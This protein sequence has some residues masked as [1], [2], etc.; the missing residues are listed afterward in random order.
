M[1]ISSY[2]EATVLLK[3]IDAVKKELE[4][5]NNQD[6]NSGIIVFKEYDEEERREF[7]YE[8]DL[9]EDMVKIMFNTL[10]SYYKSMLSK[11]EYKFKKL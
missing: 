9:P 8:F 11:L 3:E 7:D 5:L 2:N 10:V 6:F 1:E 4:R